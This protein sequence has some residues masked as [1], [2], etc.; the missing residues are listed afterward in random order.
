MI[1]NPVVLPGTVIISAVGQIVDN[2]VIQEGDNG[3]DETVAR[4]SF[5]RRRWQLSWHFD[6]VENVESF[7]EVHGRHTGFLIYP[8]RGRDRIAVAQLIGTGDA[9]E[10]VFQLTLTRTAGALSVTKN[11]L[12]PVH[13]TVTITLDG[14]GQSEGTHYSVNYATGVITFVSAPALDAPVVADFQFY[15]AVRWETDELNTV[16]ENVATPEVRQQ[17]RSATV[18]ELLNK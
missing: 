16:V 14:A 8:P 18:V 2:S 4:E 10:T 13:S 7:F 12:H 3:E 5:P 15:T 6:D 1:V 11:I 9:S 17:I